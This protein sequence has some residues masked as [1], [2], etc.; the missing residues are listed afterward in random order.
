MSQLI[1]VQREEELV[2][3]TSIKKA[4]ATLDKLLQEGTVVKHKK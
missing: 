2:Y 4:E 1:N 3:S